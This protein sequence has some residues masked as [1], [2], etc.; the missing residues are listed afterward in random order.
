MILTSSLWS[1]GTTIIRISA[2]S[3]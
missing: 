2:M 3:P 1:R